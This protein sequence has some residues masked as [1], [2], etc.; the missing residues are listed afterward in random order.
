MLEKDKTKWN[1]NR[2]EKTWKILE[3]TVWVDNRLKPIR[4]DISNIWQQEEKTQENK[5]KWLHLN[6]ERVVRMRESPHGIIRSLDNRRSM[7]QIWPCVE[8]TNL[9][10][11]FNV[12]TSLSFEHVS[13]RRNLHV[14]IS[15]WWY[16]SLIGLFFMLTHH[17][18]NTPQLEL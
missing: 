16:V 1:K 8:Q 7:N 15:V 11:V 12:G 5:V 14:S 9:M 3:H 10:R 2:I 6:G 13:T 18:L 17:R 4:P